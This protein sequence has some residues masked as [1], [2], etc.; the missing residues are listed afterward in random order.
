MAAQVCRYRYLQEE[1]KRG[2]GNVPCIFASMADPALRGRQ[3]KKMVASP[4]VEK[5]AS[6]RSVKGF[7]FLRWGQ[8]SN[9]A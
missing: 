9:Y 5:Q 8:F 7:V 1:S 3:L 6:H 2:G 4:S